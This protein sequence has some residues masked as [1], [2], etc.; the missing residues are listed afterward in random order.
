MFSSY[1]YAKFMLSWIQVQL[2]ENNNH[3]TW[4]ANQPYVNFSTSMLL[5]DIQ[6]KIATAFILK[7]LAIMYAKS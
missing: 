7:S 4:V 5:Q 1:F 6:L 2:A 3:Q